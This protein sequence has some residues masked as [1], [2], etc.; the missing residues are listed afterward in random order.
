MKI[1]KE[2]QGSTPEN[3]ILNVNSTSNTDTYSCSY[4]NSLLE[5]LKTNIED[6]LTST[7]TEN[8]L[9]ANQGRILN[10]TINAINLFKFQ[11]ICDVPDGIY[12]VRLTDYGYGV[13]LIQM[14]CSDF[15]G[16]SGIYVY[17]S[18][19]D[20][21]QN[22]GFTYST[23]ENPNLVTRVSCNPE[24]PDLLQA[25]RSDNAWPAFRRVIKLIDF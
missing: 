12:D 3:K 25:Y 22:I 4:T 23:L 7:S 20:R 18:N 11:V 16:P 19:T 2:Y 10:N 6:N 9:S 15:N 13:Y 21:T 1:K 17:R 24:Y 14:E 5:N 8:A